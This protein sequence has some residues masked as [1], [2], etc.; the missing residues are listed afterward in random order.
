MWTRPL[1][2]IHQQ[3]PL[4]I[5]TIVTALAEGVHDPSVSHFMSSYMAA[6]LG[7]MLGHRYLEITR[8]V[9]WEEVL[10]VSY[11]KHGTYSYAIM[12]RVGDKLSVLNHP[13][14]F[15]D[16]FTLLLEST[17][18]LS[19]AERIL[20]TLKPKR[21][22]I[23]APQDKYAINVTK[24]AKELKEQKLKSGESDNSNLWKKSN[25]K[26]IAIKCSV[27]LCSVIQHWLTGFMFPWDLLHH[28]K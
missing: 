15:S 1:K 26:S 24:F 22:S 11:T 18:L 20:P 16:Q 2:V 14:V 9:N 10:K 5:S 4:C 28:R 6:W 8:A 25:G 17:R 13:F 12:K 19:A 3:D 21:S 7:E 23:Y 27:L